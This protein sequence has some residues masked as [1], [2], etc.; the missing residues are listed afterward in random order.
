[1]SQIFSMTWRRTS[2]ASDRAMSS[3]ATSSEP[4]KPRSMA[5]PACL[6]PGSCDHHLV[7]GHWP[8]TRIE[9]PLPG[10]SPSMRPVGA[11]LHQS[12]RATSQIFSCSFTFAA[13]SPSI[14]GSWTGVTITTDP[15]RIGTL[16]LCL[17]PARR[18]SGATRSTQAFKCTT[19]Q[20]SSR[21]T[22]RFCGRP[23]PVVPIQS[24]LRHPRGTPAQVT[25]ASFL[26]CP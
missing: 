26:G 13:P 18:P 9:L 7:P 24:I 11:S 6:G 17:L 20:I 25:M 21:V 2:L 15:S 14:G 1:M 10:A 23:S 4:V 5:S 12:V 8:S 22:S 16:A 3:M 19:P